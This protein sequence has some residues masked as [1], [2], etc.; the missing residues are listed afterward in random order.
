MASCISSDCG[1]NTTT[2]LADP[3]SAPIDRLFSV[4]TRH[5]RKNIRCKL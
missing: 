1:Q 5:K 3:V 4:F 2:V